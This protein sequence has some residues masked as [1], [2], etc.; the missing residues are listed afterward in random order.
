MISNHEKF[1]IETRILWDGISDDYRGFTAH[2]TILEFLI[3][4]E[5]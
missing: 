3:E 5:N 1:K 4:F 2:M